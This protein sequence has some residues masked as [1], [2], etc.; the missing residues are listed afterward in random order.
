[1]NTLTGVHTVISFIVAHLDVGSVS[2]RALI[3]ASITAGVK[4]FAPN[5]WSRYVHISNFVQSDV[6]IN[7]C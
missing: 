3:D 5:E 1:M 4:R 2:Q 7:R 6:A